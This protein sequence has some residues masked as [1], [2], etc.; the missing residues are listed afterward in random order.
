MLE[1]RQLDTGIVH[2][3]DMA[4]VRSFMHKLLNKQPVHVGGF[5]A[6]CCL[7][8]SVQCIPLALSAVRWR[9]EL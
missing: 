8:A 6:P 1:E 4:R 7:T 2:Y 9:A 5:L 3:G